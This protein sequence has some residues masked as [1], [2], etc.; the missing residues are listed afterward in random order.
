MSGQG[1]GGRFLE[2]FVLL[3][4]FSARLR[5]DR[6]RQLFLLPSPCP[7]ATKMYFA[8]VLPQLASVGKDSDLAPVALKRLHCLRG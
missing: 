3:V 5:D 1:R 4:W 6:D 7:T 2:G 8:G